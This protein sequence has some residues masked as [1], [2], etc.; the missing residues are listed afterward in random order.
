MTVL[1]TFFYGFNTSA[2]KESVLFRGWR[3]RDAGQPEKAGKIDPTATTHCNS[4]GFQEM[5]LQEVTHRPTRRNDSVSVDDAVPG[6]LHG[7]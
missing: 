4:F 2:I 6:K 5:A 7:F 3:W 1:M